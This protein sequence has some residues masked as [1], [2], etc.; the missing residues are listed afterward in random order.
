[1]HGWHLVVHTHETRTHTHAHTDIALTQTQTFTH[2]FI[3]MFDS[4]LLLCNHG[5]V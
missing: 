2:G 1:M 3:E 5:P 4:P